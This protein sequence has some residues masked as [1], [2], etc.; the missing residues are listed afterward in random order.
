[1]EALPVLRQ[2]RPLGRDI[3]RL[4]RQKN[5]AVTEGPL[6][7]PLQLVAAERLLPKEARLV[8]GTCS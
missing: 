6:R 1:M 7:P 3:G 4:Q 8:R 2:V 5:G